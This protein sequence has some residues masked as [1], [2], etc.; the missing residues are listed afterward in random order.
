MIKLLLPL[1]AIVFIGCQS[2]EKFQAQNCHYDGAF[3]KGA[4]DA[5]E[6]KS[7]QGEKL[8]AD[9]PENKRVEVR[10]GY[11][12][13]FDTYSKEN[14]SFVDVIKDRVKGVAEGKPK[15]CMNSPKDDEQVCGYGCI[16]TNGQVKCAQ[17]ANHA[18]ISSAGKVYCGLNCRETRPGKVSCDEKE[19]L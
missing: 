12:E 13:G 14:K 6:K 15:T 2:A 17:S 4:N 5:K 18:C 16:E 1:F 11:R 7:L 10:K 8:V 9:C 3:E 19:V